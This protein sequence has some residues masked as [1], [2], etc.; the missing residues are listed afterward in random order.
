MVRGGK[1]DEGK[2]EKG[3]GRG[4]RCS[5]PN[6]KTCPWS[7]FFGGSHFISLALNSCWKTNAL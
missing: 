3:R 1:E 7:I 6:F 2:D 5:S 4:K